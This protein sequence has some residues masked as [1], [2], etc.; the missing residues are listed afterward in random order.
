MTV[1]RRTR[2]LCD[3][4]M[5]WRVHEYNAATRASSAIQ[6]LFERGLYRVGIRGA[7]TVSK[8]ACRPLK[9]TRAV[10]RNEAGASFAFP[11]WDSYWGHYFYRGHA[12]E[13][14]LALLL[15]A[16]STDPS[17]SFLDCGANYGFWSAVARPILGGP[18]VAVELSPDVFRWLEDNAKGSAITAVNAAVWNEDGVNMSI[19]Q[20]GPNQSHSAFVDAN[21][22]GVR[23]RSVDS[24]VEEFSMDPGH[25]LVKVDCEGAELQVLDGAK[26]TAAG[27][28][29]FVLEDHGA[30]P[31]CAVSQRVFDLGWQLAVYDENA[32]GWKAT[33]SIDDVRRIKTDPAKG[34]NVVAWSGTRQPSISNAFVS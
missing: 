9:N 1:D 3:E 11:A 28:A 29:L 14:E 34:Y 4:T 32:C 24:L 18:V 26:T 19:L 31:T 21:G 25:L 12:Y 16:Q 7:S 15:A 17:A 5:T 8:A 2:Q 33:T 23:S 27:G 22:Q 30:D 13:P 6:W 20:E 10:V